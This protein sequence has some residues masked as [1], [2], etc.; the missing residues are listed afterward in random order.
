M[1][2]FLTAPFTGGAHIAVMFGNADVFI[3][4]GPSIYD[5][6]RF[7]HVQIIFPQQ[8]RLRW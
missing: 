4:P 3:Q 7:A 6:R 1:S 5:L 2:C 8:V